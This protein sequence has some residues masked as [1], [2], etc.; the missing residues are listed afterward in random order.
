MTRLDTRLGTADVLAAARRIE[1]HVLRTPLLALDA[2]PGVLLKAEHGQRGG[3]F[4]I[5]GAANALLAEP[6]GEVVTGSSGNHGIAVAT[7]GRALGVP[8][9][10]VMAEGASRAKAAALRRLGATVLEAPGGVDERDRLAREHAALSG[11]GLVPSSDHELVV[12]GQGTVGLEILEDVPGVDVVFV[13]TGGGGLLAG[14]CLAARD[15]PVR[16]VGVEPADARRYALSLDRGSPVVVPPSR[17]IADGLRGQRPGA[18]T[19]PVVAD[20]V[21]DLVGVTDDAITHAAA[22]L[23]RAGVHAE[24]SGAVALAGALQSGFTGTAAV[25]VSGGNTAEALATTGLA[26]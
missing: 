8:V 14:I 23:R 13:P 24:P 15:L 20:R 10:V 16:V 1:G 5:R 21:D 3:S 22:L 7:L 2:V 26:A 6:C 19:L 25:V 9:T 18:V 4:K 12:A 17:T 11:A